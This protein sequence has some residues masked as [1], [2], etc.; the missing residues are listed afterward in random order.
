MTSPPAS[1]NHAAAARAPESTPFATRRG[2]VV[3]VLSGFTLL[4]VIFFSPV[5]LGGTLLGPGDGLVFWL[6]AFLRPRAWWTTLIFAGFPIAAEPTLQTFYPLSWLCA[7]LDQWN[8]FIVSAYIIAGAGA[9]AYVFSL[10]SSVRAGVVGGLT[11]SLSGFVLAHLG[12][13]SIVH[14]AAWMPMMLWPLERMRQ[15]REPGWI[16]IA[17]LAIANAVLG[18]HP[19][20]WTYGLGLAAAYAVVI[21]RSAPS[22]RSWFYAWGLFAFVTGIGLA[23]VQLVPAMELIRQTE[24]GDFPFSQFVSFALPPREAL[25]LLF[26]NLYGTVPGS[27]YGVVR[28][29]A[30]S[31]TETAAYTSWIPLGLAAIALRSSADRVVVRF[32]RALAVLTLLLA[33]GDAT[34]LA[35]LVHHLPV[36]GGFRCPARGLV[37][38]TLA[39]ATLAGMGMAALER[40]GATARD[41]GRYGAAIVLILA[42]AA[43]GTIVLLRGA[44]HGAAAAAGATELPLLPWRNPTVGLPLL[45]AVSGAVLIWRYAARPSRS[46]ATLL[47]LVTILD[48][49]SFGWFLEWRLLAPK[50]TGLDA[51]PAVAPYRTALRASHGRLFPQ[52]L[53]GPAETVPPNRN[54]LWQ[55]A[56]ARGLTSVALR[57]YVDLAGELD[58]PRRSPDARILDMLAV[59]YVSVRHDHRMGFDWGSERRTALRARGLVQ[60]EWTVPN[61][62]ATNVGIVAALMDAETLAAGTAVARVDVTTS[63]G[64]VMSFPLRAGEHLSEWTYERDGDRP[65]VQHRPATPFEEVSFAGKRGHWYLTRLDLAGRQRI[66]GIRIAST[67]SQGVVVVDRI[68]LRDEATGAS[69]PIPDTI[70]DPSRWRHVEDIGAIEV[71]ENLQTMPRAWLVGRVRTLPPDAVLTALRRAQLPDGEPFDPSTL[72]LLEDRLDLVPVPITSGDTVAVE[73]IDETT[74]RL[75][76]RSTSTAFL[77]VSDTYYPGWRAF[78]DGNPTPLYRTNYLLRGLV[79]PAGEHVIEMAFR[80]RSI[81]VGLGITFGALPVL[82]VGVFACRRGEA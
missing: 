79:V 75:R 20:M 65:P 57:R 25:Q 11:F 47:I 40:D 80:P 76:T 14:G 50:R 2:H 45:F 43:G 18:G 30:S 42:A 3:A 44:I 29:G 28:F 8:A 41:L 63:D 32:W 70:A 22:G 12:H 77:V 48:L 21:G 23:A 78:V 31:I 26:P 9:Y 73:H 51:P 46:R 58:D 64:E 82:A 74:M 10:T 62:R 61:L 4:F 6:P 72:A 13:A 69:Y 39:I 59:R 81:L 66:R 38:M 56:N 1:R 68:S 27:A 36:Y 17:A 71:Y 53:F 67:A 35:R 24:R 16:V 34:P 37:L 52:E 55:I 19:Q 54:I 49:A 7:Q 5:L 33:L 15:R 60:Q